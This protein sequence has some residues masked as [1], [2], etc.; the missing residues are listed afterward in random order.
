MGE[1][2]N[3][4][5]D[6][7]ALDEA[8]P[9]SQKTA[10]ELDDLLRRPERWASVLGWATLAGLEFGLIGPFGSYAA[11]VFTRIVYWTGLFWIGC[12]IVWPCVVAAL[13][14]G[15][16]KGF[17]P[18]FSGV[19]AILFA[20]VPLSALAA[21]CTYLFWPVRASSMRPLEWYGLTVVVS[22]PA[23]AG[24]VWLELGQGSQI[25]ARLG[26]RSAAQ[27]REI[28]G[29][30]PPLSLPSSGSTPLPDH[31]L[32]SA[33]CL[34]MEDH[35]VR[36]HVHGR[37]YLHHAVMRDVMA[38]MA[39][40]SGLQ[41]HRSWWVA[42]AALR[43]WYK[44]GR[45]ATLLLTNDLHVPVARNRLAILREQGWLDDSAELHGVAIS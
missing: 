24:L 39:E 23:V 34:Q 36:V 29:G 6:A 8:S 13:M 11:N 1:W 4:G 10:M 28:A 31:L 40:G 19:A 30:A 18:L 32:A 14:L 44:D 37:S 9:M 3:A 33:L 43:G 41:V 2:A 25:L 17:P 38:S 15:S 42:R 21:G 5:A 35:H 27:R 16:R 45:S 12:I 22:M 26:W 20:S 7:Q